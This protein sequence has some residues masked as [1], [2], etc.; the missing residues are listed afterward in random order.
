MKEILYMILIILLTPIY[1]IIM[2]LKT[3]MMWTF[4][5]VEPIAEI[6]AE[7]IDNMIEFWEKV[8]RKDNS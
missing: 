4:E 3:I 8:F 1:I 5:A 7:F 2:V 6:I